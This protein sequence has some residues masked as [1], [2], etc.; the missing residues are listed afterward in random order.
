MESSAPHEKSQPQAAIKPI[1]AIENCEHINELSVFC[2][3]H[4]MALCND[5]YFE[6]HTSCGKGMTLKQ[7]ASQQIVQFENILNECGEALDSCSDMQNRL[8][9]QEGLEEEVLKKVNKQYEQLKAIIDEQKIE[10]Q[11]TIKHLESV[12]DYKPPPKDF[13]QDTLDKLKQF[14]TEIKTKI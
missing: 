12:Q 4:D 11:N 7:A 14:E 3:A 13:S 5:C 6:N 8:Q 1:Q 10:A 9:K 2:Q